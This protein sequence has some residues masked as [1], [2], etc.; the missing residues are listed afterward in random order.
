[1]ETLTCGV[2]MSFHW[3]HNHIGTQLAALICT[4]E[5]YL[6]GLVERADHRIWHDSAY[7]HAPIRPKTQ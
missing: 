5:K 6:K 2:A 4:D 7:A 1:M 3:V